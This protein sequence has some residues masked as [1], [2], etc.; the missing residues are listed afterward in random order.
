LH[1]AAQPAAA[2][3]VADR[4]HVVRVAPG[5]TPAE[6]LR[7]RAPPRARAREADGGLKRRG[8]AVRR[9]GSP[10]AAGGARAREEAATRVAR[11]AACSA[12]GWLA[13]ATVMSCSRKA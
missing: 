1:A 6:L 10:A 4:L 9:G 8:A 3:P 13:L 5:R 11:A 2:H 7:A 12:A